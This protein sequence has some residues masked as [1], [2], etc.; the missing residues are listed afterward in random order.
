MD[1]PKNSQAGA[2][3]LG[4]SILGSGRVKQPDPPEAAPETEVAETDQG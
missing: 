4:G 1:Q 2:F 3:M